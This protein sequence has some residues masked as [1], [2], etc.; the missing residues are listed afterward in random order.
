MWTNLDKHSLFVW[1][2]ASSI[3]TGSRRII[4]LLLCV[5]QVAQQKIVRLDGSC[6]YVFKDGQQTNN[7]CRRF[8]CCLS[9]SDIHVLPSH[10]RNRKHFPCFYRVIETRVEV[11]ENG[12]C[13]GNTSRRRVFPQLFRVLPNFHKCFYSSIETRRTCFLFLLENSPRKITENEEHL[14]ALFIIKMYILYTAQFTR[15]KL[16]HHLCVSIEL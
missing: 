5:I 11:W 14:I 15:H 10:L 1:L 7:E 16:R 6:V 2:Y 3:K 4:R 13:C 8:Y 12:K 9:S